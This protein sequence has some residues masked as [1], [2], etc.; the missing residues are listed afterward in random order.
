MNTLTILYNSGDFH[1]FC[2]QTLI[3][4]LIHWDV[5]VALVVVAGTS[6][7]Q[8]QQEMTKHPPTLTIRKCTKRLAKCAS[9]RKGLVE[10]LPQRCVPQ[11]R[12]WNFRRLVAMNL[13]KVSNF[14]CNQEH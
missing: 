5:G 1:R 6:L 3:S 11:R 2:L 7:V 14:G 4:L 9:G 10:V 8:H 13:A 12:P